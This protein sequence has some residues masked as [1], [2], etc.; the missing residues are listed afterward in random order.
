MKKTSVRGFLMLLLTAIIWGFAFV[1]QRVGMDYV[2]PFT[3]SCARCMIGGIVLLPCIAAMD[4]VK[5][6]RGTLEKPAKSNS[7]S[8]FWGLNRTLLTGGILCGIAL[9][10]AGNLQQ[11]GIS[12]TS[13]GKAGFITA[14]YIVLVPVFGIFLKKKIGVRIWLSVA[15]AVAGLYLL[16]IT[17]SFSI[18]FGDFLMLL[19]AV[20]FAVQILIVDYYS[21]MV[22]P[23]RLACIQFFVSGILSGIGM[24]LFEKPS[25]LAIGQAWF[26]IAYAGVLSCGVAYTLQI[27]AQR[28]MDPTIASLI[29]SLESV[30][31]LLAGWLILGQSLSTR[32]LAGCV[33]MFAAIILAQLPSENGVK[34]KK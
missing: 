1:A 12:Y 33:L 15:L 18:G 19:C 29:M 11:I 30:V 3:F 34:K 22:D 13:V 27:I 8:G 21:P 9:G 14:M 10:V 25:L 7:K 4:H 24:L 6:K 5:E 32:E 20:A 23:V 17:E 31:S 28:D 2:G 26:P 16:C